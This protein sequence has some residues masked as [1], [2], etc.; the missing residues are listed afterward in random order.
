M[1]PVS[2]YTGCIGLLPSLF[3]VL[4][5]LNDQAVD[6]L[7]RGLGVELK[8]GTVLSSQDLVVQAAFAVGLELPCSETRKAVDPLE[9]CS[10]KLRTSKSV[11]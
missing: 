6:T 4:S 10:Y 7:Y 11:D 5:M 3:S 2:L 8:T 9:Q 1:E